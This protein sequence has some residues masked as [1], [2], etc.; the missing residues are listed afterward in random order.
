M[1]LALIT[2]GCVSAPQVWEHVQPGEVI[3]GD[4]R[5]TCPHCTDHDH[6]HI[7][8]VAEVSGALSSDTRAVRKAC[9]GLVK[10]GKI[11][12]RWYD[13][14]RSWFLAFMCPRHFEDLGQ[15]D[16]PEGYVPD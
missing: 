10:Q 11:F 9:L 7:W 15:G 16:Q 13:N 8:S 1:I 4:H 2:D 5:E 12:G 3:A 6:M 14:D